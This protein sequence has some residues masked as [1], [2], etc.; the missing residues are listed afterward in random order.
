MIMCDHDDDDDD[1]DDDLDYDDGLWWLR[2]TMNGDD[3]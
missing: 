1:A 3:C 2:M